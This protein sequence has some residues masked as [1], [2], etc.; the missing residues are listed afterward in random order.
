MTGVLI[1]RGED[2]QRYT[3]RSRICDV[4]AEIRMMCP[5]GQGFLGGTRS[6]KKQG[7]IFPKRLWR[8]HGSADTLIS[9]F[10]HWELWEN[11][12]LLFSGTQFVMVCSGSSRKL[13]QASKAEPQ[14]SLQ[15][16]ACWP[17]FFLSTRGLRMTYF[18]FLSATVTTARL[19][20]PKPSSGVV[21]N[22]PRSSFSCR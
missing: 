15:A 13:I 9:N 14:I 3:E 16:H 6:W 19:P 20:S 17:H 5:Q 10:L 21:P 4:G 12:F 22:F 2:K 18:P 7:W 11:K 8:E 1:K